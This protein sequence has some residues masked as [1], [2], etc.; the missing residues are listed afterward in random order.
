MKK[1]ISVS[2]LNNFI[3]NENILQAFK[4]FMAGGVCTLLDFFLLYILTHY[5]GLNYLKSSIFSFMSGTFINYYI[6]TVWIFSIR[7][8]ENKYREFIYYS[9]ITIVGLSI[10]TIL[11]FTFTEIF[12]FYFMLSKLMAVFVT[13]WWNFGARK[14][15]LHTIKN[16]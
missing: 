12:H 1:K 15:F 5:F 10:N 7:V 16:P 13:Y 3:K 2:S 14:Y 6:C 9:I 8:I 4:Y 11:I